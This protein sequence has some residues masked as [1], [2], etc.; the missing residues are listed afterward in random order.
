MR[1]RLSFQ[2]NIN[3]L[4]EPIQ[5]DY[6]TDLISQEAFNLHLDLYKNY[7]K[8]TNSKIDNIDLDSYNSNGIKLHQFYFENI[9]KINNLDS[10]FMVKFF[11]DNFNGFDE[12]KNNFYQLCMEIRPAG[13]CALIYDFITQK[14]RNVKIIS[15]DYGLPYGCKIVCL[16]DIFEHS[17]VPDYKTDKKSYIEKFF[18][19]INFEALENRIKNI[20]KGA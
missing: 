18:E 9:G 11:D 10:E 20:D 12:W 2:E 5:F 14:Y 3:K 8:Q 4:I 6:N 19:C 7:I 13:W 16:I 15:H 17:F 1:R